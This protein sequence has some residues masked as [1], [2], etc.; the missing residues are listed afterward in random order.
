[1]G[2]ESNGLIDGD[3]R[4]AQGD[5]DTAM[6]PTNHRSDVLVKEHDIEETDARVKTLLETHGDEMLKVFNDPEQDFLE[7]LSKILFQNN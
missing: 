7:Y 4:R 5:H 6:L 1:M 3:G 2:E